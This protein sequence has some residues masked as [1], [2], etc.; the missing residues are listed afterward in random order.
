M[1]DPL[2]SSW[3]KLDRAKEHFDVLKA[4]LAEAV[5]PKKH[6]VVF[7]TEY[8]AEAEPP[9]RRQIAFAT[10]VAMLR[11]VEPPAL[12]D[13][14]LERAVIRI[15][16]MPTF[17]IE[18]SLLLG[19]A[20]N[21]CRASLDHLAWV[22]VKHHGS[23]LNA[24]QRQNIAFP[25]KRTSKNFVIDCNYRHLRGV[26][27]DPFVTLAERYQPYKRTIIGR[28]MRSLRNLS[29]VDKHRFVIPIASPMSGVGLA[30]E[31]DRCWQ[32]SPYVWQLW[33]TKPTVS[34]HRALKP[35]TKLYEVVIIRP[36]CEG[37]VTVNG[38]LGVYPRLPDTDLPAADL[39]D[40]FTAVCLQILSEF[41]ALL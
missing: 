35:G 16:T 23:K 1:A 37:D 11:R 40:Q 31:F 27:T 22:L 7:K 26:P 8:K 20:L 21:A 5:D 15:A 28:T 9:S 18:Q 17:T 19:E 24:K 39:I 6:P 38:Y 13:R 34:I 36:G 30:L 14:K 33:P 3:A 4:Q 2:A 29:D 12:A 10:K 25:M 41:E 32:A